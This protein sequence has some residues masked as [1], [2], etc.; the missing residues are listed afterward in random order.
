MLKP[1]VA[2]SLQPLLREFPDW[3]IVVVVDIPGKEDQWPRMGA[4]AESW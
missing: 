3:E 4:I 2:K 1:V